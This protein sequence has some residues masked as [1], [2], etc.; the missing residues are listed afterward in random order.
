MPTTPRLFLKLW[1][2]NR[3]FLHGTVI[4]CVHQKMTYANETSHD[5]LCRTKG[6]IITTC[7]YSINVCNRLGCICATGFALELE[8][9]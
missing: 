6:A 7:E 3:N 8:Y 4:V 1:I 5:E 2:T 9:G